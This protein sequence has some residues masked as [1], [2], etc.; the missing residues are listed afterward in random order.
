MLYPMKFSP[1]LK[2]FIWGGQKLK[3]YLK[4]DYGPT[5]KIGESWEISDHD[6][7]IS[8]VSNGE[9]AGKSLRWLIENY[10]RELFNGHKYSKFPLLYKF[11]GPEDDLSVQVHPDDE[12]A[13]RYKPGE[14]GKTEA[15]YVMHAR[16]GAKLIAGLKEGTTR[17]MFMKAENE[18]SLEK[19]MHEVEV[20]KGDI[21]FLPSGR[22]HALKKDII[23]NEIQQN[24]DT[25]FRLYDWG[26]LGFDGKPRP[27]HIKEAIDVM[28]FNDYAPSA[29]KK[30][31]IDDGANRHARLIDC[32]FFSIEEHELKEDKVFSCSGNF[33]VISV[34]EG[35]F[36]VKCAD[37]TLE[38]EMGE[39]VLI[40]A[41]CKNYTIVPE[42]P[43]VILLSYAR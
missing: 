3:K 31:W 21:I 6:N 5:V 38:C 37:F 19:C 40:P 12:Y 15:W 25:T 30:E 2:E 10:S 42:K 39:S 43:T 29:V 9:L 7:D 17:D 20:K 22:L 14:L 4:K 36:L 23:I 11:I 32:D 35:S 27:T 1:I 24:S 13:N 28:D 34:I 8:I 26:R 18:G 33:R 16:P 41:I